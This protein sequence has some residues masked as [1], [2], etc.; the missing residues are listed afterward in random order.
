MSNALN[1]LQRIYDNM[2]PTAA[3][4]S[5]DDFDIVRTA[6]EG[7]TL[8]ASSGMLVKP[9]FDEFDLNADEAT[10]ARWMFTTSP[11]YATIVLVNL[12]SEA[13]YKLAA[14]K[15]FA[16]HKNLH[17]ACKFLLLRLP[18]LNVAVR[19][20]KTLFFPPVVFTCIDN[21]GE[22]TSIAIERGARFHGF[23]TDL[24]PLDRM[25]EFALARGYTRANMDEYPPIAIARAHICTLPIELRKTCSSI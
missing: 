19:S 13:F 9:H 15:Y 8:D 7:Y 16:V 22:L 14:D 11:D 23:H 10:W 2:S 4:E 17:R 12:M 6:L 21:T 25:R 18:D 3:A 20:R 24:M 5:K 1:A